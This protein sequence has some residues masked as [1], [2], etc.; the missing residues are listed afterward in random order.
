MF[1][2]LGVLLMLVLHRTL[3][4]TYM[5]L[6]LAW[7]LSGLCPISVLPVPQIPHRKLES[8]YLYLGKQRTKLIPYNKVI[9]LGSPWS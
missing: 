5:E 9:D 2:L 8:V 7:I 4:W 1:D 3:A 6:Q